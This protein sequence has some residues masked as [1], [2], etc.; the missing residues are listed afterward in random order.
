VIVALLDA[1][2]PE[3]I[4]TNRTRRTAE[5]LAQELG[6]RLSVVDWIA[7]GQRHRGRAR[8]WSTRPRS[9]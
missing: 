2:E 3:V 5:A 8:S 7:A 4:L 1:G 6:D 9:A